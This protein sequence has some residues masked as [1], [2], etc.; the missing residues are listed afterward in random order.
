M[1]TTNLKPGYKTTEAWLSLLA[2]ICSTLVAVKAVPVTVSTVVQADAV[3]ALP[4]IAVGYAIA[5]SIAKIGWK[6]T[7]PLLEAQLGLPVASSTTTVTFPV[8]DPV[9]PPATTDPVATW[10]ADAG[11]ESVDEPPAPPPAPPAA[12]DVAKDVPPLVG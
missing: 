10:P 3:K 7:L 1:D 12:A 4:V 5:R 11:P 2:F 9:V 8:A 6:Q